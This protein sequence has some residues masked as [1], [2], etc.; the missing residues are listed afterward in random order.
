MTFIAG[1]Y[2]VTYNGNSLGILED[3]APLDML[4][5][6]IEITGDNEGD[7]I[8]DTI[9]RGNRVYMDMVLQEYDAAGAAAA[10][11]PWNAAVGTL[12][13]AGRLGSSIA[14][15]LVLTAVAGTTATPASLT[16]SKALLAP[17]FNVRTLFGTRLRQVPIRFM[18]LPFT[19]SAAKKFFY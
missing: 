14:Q 15:A 11:W 6:Q 19:H 10:F 12:G 18:F 4:N 8:Q 13:Q 5:S 7:T 1:P 16:F 9:L 3:A 2:T 17:N